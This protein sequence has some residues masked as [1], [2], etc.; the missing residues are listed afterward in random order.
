VNR[1]TLCNAAE[2][3]CCI[4]ILEFQF[5]NAG[6]AINEPGEVCVALLE[7]VGNRLHSIKFDGEF[8]TRYERELAINCRVCLNYL[9]KTIRAL[10]MC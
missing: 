1:Q 8:Q 7:V 2:R 9:I 5:A 6:D 4:W 3:L 10:L